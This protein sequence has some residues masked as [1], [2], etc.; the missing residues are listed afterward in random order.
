MTDQPKIR[1]QLINAIHHGK[2]RFDERWFGKGQC[3]LIVEKLRTEDGRV[4]KRVVKRENPTVRYC[5]TAPA[6][7]AQHTLPEHSYPLE[8]C[9]EFESP[10]EQLD[11]HVAELTEQMDYYNETRGPGAT[12]RRR[13]LHDHRWVHG[14]DINLVDHFIDRYM[15]TFKAELDTTSPLDMAFADIE[16]DP[17]DHV[18]FPDENDA[19]CP[20]NLITYFHKPTK[21]LVQFVL[22]NAVRENPQIAEFE[23]NAEHWRNFIL[24]EVNRA[25]LEQQRYDAANDVKLAPLVEPGCDWSIIAAQL[26][27]RAAE[28]IEPDPESVAAMRCKSVEFHFYDT[29]EEL[30]LDFLYLVNEVDRPDVLAWWNM[31]FDIKTIINR[32]RKLGIDY[33]QAFTPKDFH[34][35]AAADYRDDTFNTEP[36]DR[37]DTFD[38]TAYTI[39]VDQMLLYAQL[40]KQGGKKE[41]YTLDY[42][43]RAE[44]GENKV[45]YE[46]SIRDLAY[47]D[48]PKFMLYGA[49]DVVP[50]ATLEDKI[51]DIALA[52][53]LSMTTRTR[54]QK[55]MKKTVCLRNLAA[56]FYR[57]RGLVLSNNRNKN[58]ERTDSEK[59]KGA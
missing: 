58:K 20:V 52:Y 23:Q 38:V 40:R 19:P 34:P 31:A 43:L 41:S 39:Y 45:E 56:V 44:I 37:N 12:R 32:L 3:V 8:R 27:L 16:V 22:R 30:L 6:F 33:E 59:F 14:S 24:C 47:R 54:F 21:R 13:K 29:E 2:A 11:R 17:I 46:G 57:E 4:V 55:I 7:R 9:E 42:T 49:I 36:T 51:E 10:V 5:V 26:G 53:Q 18:G 35:W 25:I 15:E 48:F 28:G 50:L 1:R